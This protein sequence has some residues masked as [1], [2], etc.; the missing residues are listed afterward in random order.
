MSFQV[1]GGSSLLLP[2][3]PWLRPQLRQKGGWGRGGQSFEKEEA[4]ILVGN[5][6][7]EALKPEPC[8]RTNWPDLAWG[9]GGYQAG[10]GGWALAEGGGARPDSDVHVVPKRSP[11]LSCDG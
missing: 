3:Q 11:G 8:L 7:N 1:G 9:E 10:R 4:G 5:H 2:H 6:S